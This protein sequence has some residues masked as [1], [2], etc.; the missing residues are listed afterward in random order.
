AP[1]VIWLEGGIAGDDTD[2]HVDDVARFVNPSTVVFAVETD[3]EDE[4]FRVLRENERILREARDQ[5]GDPLAVIPLPMPG[6][7]GGD[8]RL[9]ASY[10]NFFIG[11]RVVLV[12]VFSD[13]NDGKA[14]QV[15]GGLFPGRKIIP[16]DCRALVE[17]KGAIHC[18]T[19]EQP[20]VG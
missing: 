8:A 17:G 15:L 16:I 7:L 18:I 19:R 2:G 6:P 4:N 13:P 3:P 1:H 20:R 5:D 14:L 9:P 12:P 10:L 11:N